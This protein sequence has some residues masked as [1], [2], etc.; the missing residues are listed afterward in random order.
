MNEMLARIR[1]GNRVPVTI[2]CQAVMISDHW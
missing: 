1:V 2:H